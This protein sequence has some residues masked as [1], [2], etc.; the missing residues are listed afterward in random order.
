MKLHDWEPIIQQIVE[1]SDREPKE[2]VKSRRLMEWRAKLAQEPHLLQ[3]F[4]IDEIVREVRKRLTNVS[5]PPSN[6]S[7]YTVFPAAT[8]P[9]PCSLNP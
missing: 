2:S 6:G 5:P 9:S 8:M 4:Q 7:A 3:P 1:E